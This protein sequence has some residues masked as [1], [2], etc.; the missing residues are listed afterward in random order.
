MFIFALVAVLSS[1][2]SM[3]HRS[4]ERG[5]LP[6][7][8]EEVDNG[9]SLEATDYRDQTPLI[10]AAEYGEMEI[11]RYLVEQG[12]NVNATTPV[13]DGEQTPLRKAIERGDYEMV[14]FLVQ[15]GAEVNQENQFGWTPLMTAARTG[16]IEIMRYMLDEGADPTARTES[17]QTITRIAS[18]AGYTDIVVWMTL[19]LEERAAAET[20]ASDDA[21]SDTETSDG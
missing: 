14:R 17:G 7:I 20:E 5:D 12:A 3:I 19:L 11:V 9:E 13:G 1:C 10:M 8:R 16:N 4:I 2:I 6:R 18:D 15:N 21:A